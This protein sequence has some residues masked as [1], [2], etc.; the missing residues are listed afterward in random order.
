M[1]SIGNNMSVRSNYP[2]QSP[3]TSYH[4]PRNTNRIESGEY[5]HMSGSGINDRNHKSSIRLIMTQ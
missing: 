3:A 2:Q 4:Q 5:L 1:L